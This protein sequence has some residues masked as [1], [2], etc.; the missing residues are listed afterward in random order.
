MKS[1]PT[2]WILARASGLAAYLLLTISV[3]AG[4][5]VKSRVLRALKPAAVTDVHRFLA[6]L[7]LGGIAIHGLTLVLDNVVDIS[8][9]ALVVP[10]RISYRPLWTSVGVVSAE[11]MLVIY[12]SFSIRRWI[13]FKSWRKLHYLTFAVFAAAS[14][15]GLMA[16]SDSNNPWV[17]DIYLGAIGAV[18]AATTWRVLVPPARPSSRAR[19]VEA[20]T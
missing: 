3:V 12:L 9:T 15:H 13:G 16:G 2:F 11:L 10:G 8:L 5:A 6:L 20:Q 19:S 4:L 17:L 14:V 7:G 1:D 18:A